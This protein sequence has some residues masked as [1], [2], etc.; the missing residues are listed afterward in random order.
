ML[1][2]VAF[3]SPVP[4]AAS[5]RRADSG[6]GHGQRLLA[7]DVLAGLERGQRLFD[8]EVVGRRHVDDVDRVVCE[9]IRQGRVGQSNTEGIR[10]LATATGR[11]AEDAAHVDADPAQGLDMNRADEAGPDDRGA[12]VREAG[13]G[14]GSLLQRRPV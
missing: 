1:K 9:E 10:P 13:H 12:D 4:A 3:K 14:R 2:F 8:V 6:R 5:T 7:H 11:R